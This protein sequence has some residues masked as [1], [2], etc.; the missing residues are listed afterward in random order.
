MFPPLTYSK[1]IR[2]FPP[3]FNSHAFGLYI[4]LPADLD[5]I[6]MLSSS[7]SQLLTLISSSATG[8]SSSREWPN[9]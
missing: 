1:K 7:L 8:I 5:M 3:F 6:Y 9:P 4:N 2:Y